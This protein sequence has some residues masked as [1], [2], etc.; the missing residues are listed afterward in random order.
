[1]VSFRTEGEN[2]SL[3]NLD[4]GI[5][6]VMILLLNQVEVLNVLFSRNPFSYVYSF[7]VRPT[8]RHSL[9]LSKNRVAYEIK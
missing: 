6:S 1:M 5:G 8:F 9:R 2:L 4:T 7:S 3:N